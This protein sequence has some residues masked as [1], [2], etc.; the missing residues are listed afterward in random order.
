MAHLPALLPD[1]A[2]MVFNDSR[3]R[4]A[5]VFAK[6]ESG[7]IVEFLFTRPLPSGDWEA[8][9]TKMKKQSLGKRYSFP[10]G[11]F[12]EIAAVD[13][14][15]RVVRFSEP[16]EE[17]WFEVHGHVPL[18]PYI[19]RNDAPS[20]ADRYQTVYSRELGSVA[21]PTA[22]LHF[23]QPI[24][25]ALDDKGI[26]RAYVTLHVGMG[27]FLPVRTERIADHRMHSERFEIPQATIDAVRK[28]KRQGRPIIAV[29]TT[30]VRTLESAWEGGDFSRTAGDTDIFIS[31][32]YEFRAIDG[33][34]TNF[35]TPESTLLMLVC[36]FAGKERVFS[37]YAEA[38]E[39]KYRFFSYGDA[40]LLL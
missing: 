6:A 22:G 35:H 37:A 2:L 18:P 34:F 11:I 8:T 24:L 31:P 12:G 23:T 19:K 9:C 14:T 15:T 17:S 21:A 32:G 29:G 39:R 33:M 30:S 26:E 27:T 20:D 5:R 40:M 38:I 25:K 1:G 28:A 10:G 4:K 13:E 16:V 7:A 3:V 36:A